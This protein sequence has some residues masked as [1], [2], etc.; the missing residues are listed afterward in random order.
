VLD[1]GRKGLDETLDT[2][3]GAGI[4]TAGAGRYEAEARAP[5]IVDVPGAGRVLVFAFGCD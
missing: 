4:R 2:L 3:H 1:W 5:A